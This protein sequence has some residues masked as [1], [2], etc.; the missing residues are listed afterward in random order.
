M[1]KTCFMFCGFKYGSL[2]Q[3]LITLTLCDCQRSVTHNR[4]FIVWSRETG[5]AV[6]RY[7]YRSAP[8][9]PGPN[10]IA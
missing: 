7:C 4:V 2:T 1:R 6:K 10:M 3:R 9:R 8:E 5:E